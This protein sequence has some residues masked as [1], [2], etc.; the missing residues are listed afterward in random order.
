MIIPNKVQN[1]ERLRFLKLLYRDKSRYGTF[2]R[3]LNG[4]FENIGS[5]SPG[6]L[7]SF[8]RRYGHLVAMDGYFSVNDY[9]SILPYRT[10]P[11]GLPATKRT[12]QNVHNLNACYV[13]LD[14]G[15]K[16]SMAAAKARDEILVG[17]GTDFPGFSAII[18]SGRGLYVLWFL[19]DDNG[20]PVHANSRT[21]KVYGRVQR[22]LVECFGEF[23]ADPQC[24]D[25]TRVLRIPGTL[26]S[27]SGKQ[28]RIELL[29][30]RYFTL[31]SLASK[32]GIQKRKKRTRKTRIGRTVRNRAK[33]ACGKEGFIALHEK[34]TADMLALEAKRGGFRKGMRRCAIWHYLQFLAGAGVLP[35]EAFRRA[36]GMANR[37]R[38]PYD[39]LGNES[40]DCLVDRVYYDDGRYKFSNARLISDLKIQTTECIAANLRTIIT[41]EILEERQNDRFRITHVRRI[42]SQR[43]D[44]IVRQ[45]LG[46]FPNCS[47]SEM[48]RILRRR[49]I[50]VSRAT[51]HRRMCSSSSKN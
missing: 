38:P 24:V 32:L 26:H 31:E 29:R 49:G 42:H 44:E 36:Q 33:S 28:A 41:T 18:S 11:F 30:E 7:R 51:A 10:K 17:A 47:C 12:N 2:C 40:V 48:Q 5:I 15:R 50:R 34:R 27:K 23:Q 43:T 21:R 3:K 45:T 6:D 8:F 25:A 16:C 46:T 9:H 13:D 22:A 20:D 39:E 37:C 1:D 14:V 35:E 4:Q 19:R